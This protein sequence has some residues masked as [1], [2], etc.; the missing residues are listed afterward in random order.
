MGTKIL[1]F[2]DDVRDAKVDYL[3]GKKVENDLK[4]KPQTPPPASAPA[5]APTYAV[6]EANVRD[7]KNNSQKRLATDFWDRNRKQIFDAVIVLG[8]IY[9]G[10]KLFFDRGVTGEGAMTTEAVP[11]TAEAI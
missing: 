6:D 2:S 5:P 4:G 10:Y 8:V 11:D 1:G 7:L 9:L 3:L